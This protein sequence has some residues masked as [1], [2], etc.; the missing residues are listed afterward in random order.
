MAGYKE[1]ALSHDPKCFITFDGDTLFET[2]SWYLRQDHITDESG[3]N[4]FGVL[5]QVTHD[6]R[7]YRM[8]ITGLVE[9]EQFA[10]Q[11]AFQFSPNGYDTNAE[12]PYEKTLIEIFDHDDFKFR[13]EFTI[14][15]L[16]RKHNNDSTF[17][18][19]RYN[20]QTGKYESGYTSKSITRTVFRKG[21]KVGMSWNYSPS[22]G[23]YLN[24]V[25]PNG[26]WNVDFPDSWFNSAQH[27]CMKREKVS[28]G[29]GLYQTI[30]YVFVNGWQ[31][32]KNVSTI[33]STPTT[34]ENTSSIELG[35][36]LGESSA[37]FLNDRQT[38]PLTID[39]FAIYDKA[40]SDN[41]IY[42]LYKKT[43]SYITLI[44]R[45]SPHYYL[46]MDD[47]KNVNKN[48]LTDNGSS[49]RQ[50]TTLIGTNDYQHVRRQE[51][52]PQLAF[53]SSVKFQ[54]GGML[55]YR[56]ASNS[57]QSR[58]SLS[59]NYTLEF[60]MKFTSSNRGV[61]CSFQNE[62]NPFQGILI[63]S[64]VRNNEHDVGSIQFSTR[65]GIYL[66]TP[67]FKPNGHK[68]YFNDDQ[69][70]LY[71]IIRRGDMFEVWI[72]GVKMGECNTYT[73]T[74][75]LD[76]CY[77]MGMSPGN[78]SVDGSLSHVAMYSKA[79]QTQQM[80]GRAN[81]FVKN[82]I[83]GRITVQGS[84]HKALIR[85]YDHQSGELL[86]SGNSDGD[87]GDYM[88]NVFTNNFIDIMVLDPSDNNIRYKSFGPLLATTFSDY[89]QL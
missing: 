77:W 35:G 26:N 15:F 13:D 20:A 53:E 9:R 10:G 43:I 7:S 50:Y 30:D 31:Y 18:G 60:W 47:V 33:T 44:Q 80:V 89:D 4:H 70:R 83:R 62:D 85:V 66:C 56:Y 76:A 32:I 73:D 48:Y 69:W 65:D 28:L 22:S 21:V 25:M 79:L 38:S 17:R 84:P 1:T 59:G 2:G 64:N 29:G 40:L 57:G 46:P 71:H 78:L 55:R 68:I 52:P 67:E 27:V 86:M 3:H 51:S 37:D 74:I 61:I 42:N 11:F 45:D 36:T 58:F 41:E 5:H 23:S 75:S 16:F 81:F 82:L 19:Q 34:G 87:T 24:F 39:Q 6:R 88:L 8:G 49:S 54:N 14:M 72:D 63:Q 12:F